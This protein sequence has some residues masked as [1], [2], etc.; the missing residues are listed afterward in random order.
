M[1]H[2]ETMIGKTVDGRLRRRLLIFASLSCPMVSIA[3]NRAFFGPGIGNE[4]ESQSKPKTNEALSALCSSR[5]AIGSGLL[6]EYFDE[7]N[8]KGTMLQKKIDGIIDS[9]QLR[10]TKNTK[11]VKWSGWIKTPI[12]GLHQFHL[13]HPDAK[14]FVSKKD[15][16]FNRNDTSG[17]ET[18]TGSFYAVE[19]FLLKTIKP[20]KQE[21]KLEWTP[22][23]GY[24]YPISSAML[25]PPTGS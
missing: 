13:D 6:G 14:I 7:E 17:I 5:N 25:F 21:F 16:S 1:N 2:D 20:N 22:P 11:S 23:H 9:N 19:I 15:F 12:S 18:K 10:L 8:C 24:K 4:T 3:F